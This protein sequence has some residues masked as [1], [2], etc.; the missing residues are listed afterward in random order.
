[1]KTFLLVVLYSLM[2][3][4][5]VGIVGLTGC[6]SEPNSANPHSKE[7]DNTSPYY[8]QKYEIYTFEGCEYIVGGVGTMRW[9]AHK[10]NCK[11]SIHKK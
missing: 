10:G 4:L 11:N 7:L 5:I 2:I 3:M 6:Q 1:M 9:G 8:N